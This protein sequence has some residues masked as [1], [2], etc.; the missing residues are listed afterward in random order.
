[1]VFIL[2]TI[3]IVKVRYGKG[4]IKPNLIFYICPLIHYYVGKAT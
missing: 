4:E 3:F 2:S 1:M